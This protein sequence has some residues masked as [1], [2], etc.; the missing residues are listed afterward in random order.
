MGNPNMCTGLTT[1]SKKHL[2]QKLPILVQADDS[3]IHYQKKFSLHLNLCMHDK[4][5]PGSGAHA[6]PSALGLGNN[7]CEICVMLLLECH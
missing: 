5:T 1:S 3:K 2:V 6:H 4:V 7:S